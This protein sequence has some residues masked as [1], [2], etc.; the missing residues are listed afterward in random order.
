MFKAPFQICHRIKS[1]FL[2]KK[3]SISLIFKPNH[4]FIKHAYKSY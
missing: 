4:L 1:L 2:Y 3:K